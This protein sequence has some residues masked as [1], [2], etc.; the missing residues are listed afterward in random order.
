MTRQLPSW[1]N[2]QLV[3][4]YDDVCQLENVWQNCSLS[5]TGNWTNQNVVFTKA[6]VEYV[7]NRQ[8]LLSLVRDECRGAHY[9]PDFAM[10]GIAATEPEEQ[11]GSRALV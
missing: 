6:V 10:P 1:R 7:S 11:R 5:D 3:Q 9:K 8:L 4:A 2:D